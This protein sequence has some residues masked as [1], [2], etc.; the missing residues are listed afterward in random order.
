[1][2]SMGLWSYSAFDNKQ[3]R[4]CFRRHGSGHRLQLSGTAGTPFTLPYS[5]RQVEVE[6]RTL[7]RIVLGPYVPAVCFH[8]GPT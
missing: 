7:I 1:M 3:G 2:L 6:R 8:N 4:R 5:N